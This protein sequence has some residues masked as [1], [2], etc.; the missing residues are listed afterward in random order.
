VHAVPPALEMGDEGMYKRP[1]FAVLALW[2]IAIVSTLVVVR[3]ER[4]FT[5][6]GPVYFVCMVGS[7][8]AARRAGRKA[9]G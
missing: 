6:L 2:L 5:V 9:G 3:D 4:S 1:E 7:I 8:V